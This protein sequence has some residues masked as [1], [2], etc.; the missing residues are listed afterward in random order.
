M[1]LSRKKA[2]KV[3]DI[4]GLDPSSKVELYHD[5]VHC[6]NLD[7]SNN[8]RFWGISVEEPHTNDNVFLVYYYSSDDA[9]GRTVFDREIRILRTLYPQTDHLPEDY[10]NRSVLLGETKITAHGN[11]AIRAHSKPETEDYVVLPLEWDPQETSAILRSFRDAVY[12][13]VCRHL[14]STARPY[15]HQFS[16][17]ISRDVG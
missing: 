5:D 6:T 16:P 1:I 3:A 4:L 15:G 13:V 7:A 12:D 11:D 14:P 9:E 8:S 2:G 17:L 10:S